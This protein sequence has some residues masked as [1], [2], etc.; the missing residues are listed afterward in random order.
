MA[1]V[2][3]LG[4]G[5]NGTTEPF[6]SADP[7][8]VLGTGPERPLP[9][10]TAEALKNAQPTAPL[11][12]LV[13]LTPCQERCF[14]AFK[15]GNSIVV[16]GPA[17][18]GKSF[19]IARMKD[20]AEQNK[21]NIAVTALTGAAAALVNGLT[22][23]SW[24][25]IG[26]AAGS[27]EEL[28]HNMKKFRKQHIQRWFEIDILVI[29]EISMMSADLF[30]KLN[31]LAQ[32][33]RNNRHFFGGIQVVL[34]GDFCQLKPVS[35]DKEAKF[36]FETAIWQKHLTNST[37]YLNTVMRQT[38]PVFQEILAS[39]RMGSI[40]LN[41]QTILN[42][43]IITDDNDANLYVELPDGSRQTIKATTLYP[44]KNDVNETN[45]I[46]LNKLLAAGCTKQVY[47][48][49]DMVM[50]KRTKTT[51]PVTESHKAILDKCCYALS[52]ITLAIGAQVML[53][54][55]MSVET[56][57][58]N[59][60]RGV[61]VDFNKDLGYAPLVMFDNGTQILIPPDKF[62]TDSGNTTL[63][64]LQ[65]PLILAWALTIHKCQG[66]TIT[67]VITDLTGVFEEAQVYVTLSRVCSLEG[68]FI[69]GINY[70]KIKCN[71]R[72]KQYYEALNAQL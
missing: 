24:A 18:C 33:I 60:S 11:A 67:N 25:G 26:L 10:V 29:D 71:K 64:R 45:N 44:K 59:G 9:G 30:N 13:P 20:H 63:V 53:I 12:P 57:L 72:V 36:C 54:K 49:V 50:D 47:K 35:E 16:T 2:W 52:E 22:L 66:A 69:K 37:Y 34:C 14:E 65:V 31:G 1:T 62:E 5:T 40:T 48:S 55:N 42:E 51:S 17:G 7:G 32:L 38:D 21:T 27:S 41:Q 46:Q 15:T 43:R 28:Y 4:S 23:H 56:G 61:V 3:F 8:H 68:L 39:I 19:L 58:V 70:G 6:A